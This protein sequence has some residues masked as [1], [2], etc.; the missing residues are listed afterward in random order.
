VRDG[1]YIYSLRVGGTLHLWINI[2][3]VPFLTKRSKIY[4]F[5]KRDIHGYKVPSNY[6]KKFFEQK[7]EKLEANEQRRLDGEG[8]QVRKGTPMSYVG[9]NDNGDA[10]K[11]I[12]QV[13]E[14]IKIMKY[15]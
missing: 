15:L 2:A 6:I 14:E 12:I 3:F 11:E 1:S 9:N 10:D 4:L 13:H 8:E 5:S 7:E